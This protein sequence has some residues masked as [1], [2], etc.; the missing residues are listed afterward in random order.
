M[1]SVWFSHLKVVKSTQFSSYLRFSTTSLGP[2]RISEVSDSL[3]WLRTSLSP[4]QSWASCCAKIGG[5]QL[6]TICQCT[7]I[8]DCKSSSLRRLFVAKR[9]GVW[10]QSVGNIVR[11]GGNLAQLFR[12]IPWTPVPSFP[13][14]RLLEK[15]TL[16]S[17]LL[18]TAWTL[19]CMPIYSV[20]KT[21]KTKKKNLIT[22]YI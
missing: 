3:T 5:S 14:I 22:I 2:G 21:S 11:F 16:K 17:W 9:A 7:K 6:R 8:E 1:V 15:S 4:L 19:A 12:H 18:S 20:W 13:Q 10:V